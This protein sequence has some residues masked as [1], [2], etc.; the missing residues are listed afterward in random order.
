MKVDRVEAIITLNATETEQFRAND[1]TPIPW[2]ANVASGS[3]QG[4]RDQIEHIAS[5]IEY[6]TDRTVL[7]VDAN[8]GAE[9]ARF[10][11]GELEV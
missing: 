4:I 8:T 7:I 9:L 6:A 1:Q 2:C 3:Y 11:N 5:E 10:R